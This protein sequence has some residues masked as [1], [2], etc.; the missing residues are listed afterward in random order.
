LV[1]VAGFFI[2]QNRNRVSVNLFW[3]KLT[4][5]LWTI[6]LVLFLVGLA[7]GLVKFRRHR[8]VDG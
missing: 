6:L 5:P 7:A 8:A 3:L 1:V 4:A 2:G